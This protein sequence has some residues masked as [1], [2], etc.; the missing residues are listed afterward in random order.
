[1]KPFLA[2]FIGAGKEQITQSAALLLGR[3]PN[4]K[5]A[6]AA[7][8]ALEMFLKTYLITNANYDESAIV[9]YS[10][11]IKDLLATILQLILNRSY[12]FSKTTSYVSRCRRAVPRRRDYA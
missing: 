1:V 3:R 4:P 7:R 8:F 2:E 11:R 12:V 5:S 6:E 9:K 10:H